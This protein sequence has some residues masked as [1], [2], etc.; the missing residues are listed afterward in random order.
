[1]ANLYEKYRPTSVKGIVGQCPAKKKLRI[2]LRTGWGGKAFW[3]SGP[4]GSGKTTLAY[5]IARK[6]AD[7]FFI[8]E[9]DSGHELTTDALNEVESAMHLTA[10]GK[11]GRA[12]IVNEAHGLRAWMVRRLLGLLERLPSHVV[13][14]FTTT[15]EGQ[16]HLFEE[17][18]D[19]GPLL[20]R[21]ITLETDNKMLTNPFARRAK[22]IARKE[23]LDGRPLKDYID[24]VKR[25][26]GN[27][28]M[29]IQEIECGAMLRR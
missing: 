19:A 22:Q 28:R 25:C 27:M 12:F 9:F 29:I 17:N 26:G 5:I 6:G 8:T 23:H 11:G 14:I 10:S 1:M 3:I 13:F 7:D 24:L 18:V 15:A 2:M 20:S 16:L 21:C 4:S